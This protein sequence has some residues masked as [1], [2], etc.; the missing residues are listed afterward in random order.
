MKETQAGIER[1][2]RLNEYYQRIHLSVTDFITEIKPGHSMLAR[3]LPERLDP[4]LREQWWPVSVSPGMIVVERPGNVRYE[5]GQLVS[6]LGLVGEPFRYKRTLR[7]VLLIA[8]DTSPTPLMMS[9][10]ALISNGI[11]V[12]LVL[13]GDA[14]RYPTAHLPPELEVLQADDNLNWPNQVMTVG[15]ADQVFVVVKGDDEIGH[16]ANVVR[17]FQER[18]AEIP[19]M[20]LFG[21]FQ[22]PLPCGTGACQACMLAIKGAEPCLICADG[23]AV[24]LTTLGLGG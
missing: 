6:L 16:F 20:Y 8:Y 14:K 13:A 19:K 12:T 1:V 3:M 5:L 7:N 18:R 21:V 15:W 10:P 4:Y 2:T 22:P 11:S 23:P 9:V 17:I 24:D